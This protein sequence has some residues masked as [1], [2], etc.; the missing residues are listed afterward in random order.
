MFNVEDFLWQCVL[1]SVLGLKSK[2]VSE[3]GQHCTMKSF[4][5]CTLYKISLGQSN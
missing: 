4:I 5:I 2:E 1:K 3:N